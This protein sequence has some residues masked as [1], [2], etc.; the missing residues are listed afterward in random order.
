MQTDSSVPR[1]WR[2][3]NSLADMIRAQAKLTPNQL[4]LVAQS[5]TGGEERITYAQMV[6]RGEKL[7][8]GLYRIGATE[9]DHV[10]VCLD[11][12][13]AYEAIIT[14]L[15]CA[16]GGMVCVTINARF[17]EEEILHALTLAD[18]R[19]LVCD[20]A[21]WSR[22]ENIRDDAPLLNSIM[23]AGKGESGNTIPWNSV[24]DQAEAVDVVWPQRKLED[25][26]EIL[27]TSGTTARPKAALMSNR[28]ALASAYGFAQAMSLRP[29]SV[30]QSFFPFFTTA[31][32]R[33]VLYPSWFVGATAVV[34][35]ELEVEDI[36]RRMENERTTTY[37]GVPAFY[38]FLLEKYE[39]LSCDLSS[40][41]I[42]D[43]GGA[44]MPAELTQRLID[45]FPQLDVRQT[46]GQTEGGPCGTVLVGEEAL[47][48]IGS[49]GVPWVE[50]ELRI[51]DDN[52]QN[53][54]NNIIGEIA[55]RSPSLFSGYYKNE[56]ATREALRDGWLLSGDLGKLD[57]EG[58]LYIVDRKK[59]MVIRGGLNIG[60]QE[61]EAVLLRYAGVEEVAVIGIPHNKLGE[62]L[63]AVLTISP[64]AK[65]DV[66]AVRQ[67]CADKLA[68]FK[69]PRQYEIINQ[70]PRSPMGKIL[71]TELRARFKETLAE[72][73]G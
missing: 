44:A 58:Y 6:W 72:S 60:T 45:A 7:A 17:A 23:L 32:L 19:Y 4:A 18:V 57:D 22:T 41:E 48:H 42:I 62:D 15:A 5:A 52:I 54:P 69:I 49:S 68:D 39:S 34:D 13:S 29:D 36:L 56:A 24:L 40:L 3:Y 53:V 27:F 20:D 33:C 55:V 46:Y 61:V 67:F 28:S 50:T 26:L 12:K 2:E 70:M 10:G 31:C 35:P 63:L 14:L 9:N 51:V 30:Y 47:A 59:D 64:D 38:I 43:A 8:R 71:K 66:E 37:I 11:N 21:T 1:D 65:I 73:V 16:F 25:I